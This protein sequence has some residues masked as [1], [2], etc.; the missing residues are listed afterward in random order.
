MKHYASLGLRRFLSAWSG[1]HLCAL[2]ARHSALAPLQLLVELA[3]IAHTAEQVEAL[4]LRSH[5]SSS[6]RLS[7]GGSGGAGGG[8]GAGGAGY[9]GL[10]KSGASVVLDLLLLWEGQ[11]PDA[12][13]DSP[14]I[15]S[16]LSSARSAGLDILQRSLSHESSSSSSSS[17]SVE[18]AINLRDEVLGHLARFG[19]AAAAAASLHGAKDVA[20]K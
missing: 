3:D 12:K 2:A 7:I 6:A 16:S 1:L 17:S 18:P 11:M 9:S 5:G 10:Q 13:R 4:Q 19:F 14:L 8:G 15:W 20:K